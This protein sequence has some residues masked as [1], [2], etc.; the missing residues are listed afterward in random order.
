[1]NRLF[2][3]VKQLPGGKRAIVVILVVIIVLTWLAVCAI[4]TSYP[5]LQRL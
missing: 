3:L 1:M 4:L 2:Q 5:A